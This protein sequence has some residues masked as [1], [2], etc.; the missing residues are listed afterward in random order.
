MTKKHLMAVPLLLLCVGLWFTACLSGA[1]PDKEPAPVTPA[2][3][4]DRAGDN[5]P[6]T[7]G[8]TALSARTG[9]GYEDIDGL[10]SASI[11]RVDR[12]KFGYIDNN[13]D[14]QYRIKIVDVANPTVAVHEKLV[15]DNGDNVAI[16]TTGHDGKIIMV[17]AEETGYEAF[18]GHHVVVYDR[19]LTLV[20]K[21]P[22]GNP[23]GLNPG[24]AV[25]IHH[26]DPLLAVTSKYAIAGWQDKQAEGSFGACPFFISI[27][28]LTE[29]KAGHIFVYQ[30]DSADAGLGIG[31]LVALAAQGDYVI[32]GGSTGTKVFRISDSGANISLEEV[33]GLAQAD[34]GAHWMKDNQ[35]Y[36]LESTA[37]NGEVRV[38]KWNDASE[39]SVVG[40]ANIGATSGNVQ[41]ISFDN[42][43]PDT[44]YAFGKVADQNAGDVYRINLGDAAAT[45]LFKLPGYEGGGPLTGIWTIEVETHEDDTYYVLGGTVAG[46]ADDLANF[47]NRNGVLVVKNPPTSGSEI[48]DSFVAASLLDFPTAVRTMKTFK[49]ADHDIVY[50]AKNYTAAGAGFAE[51]DYRLR[52][53]AVNED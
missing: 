13:G 33:S 19:N 32:I 48:D 51:S 15:A 9:G 17:T 3:A 5:A 16:W 44:A 46:K 28:S 6:G 8:G 49:I 24:V 38:W 12:S 10:S 52:L 45:K 39:P 23:S 31:S 2:P 25:P 36:V 50:V 40:S 41:A 30:N 26:R 4:P 47:P 37:G 29:D 22:L 21:V 53:I 35:S 18:A 27:Y 34:R 7:T 43:K 42:E 1:S 11:L 20:K 14:K